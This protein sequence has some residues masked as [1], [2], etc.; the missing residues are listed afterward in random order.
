MVNTAWS[1]RIKP[2]GTLYL[3]RRLRFSDEY[4]AQYQTAFSLDP[5]VETI[6]EI[7]CGPGAFA[8][9]LARWYP[10]AHVTGI[11]LDTA[12]I[13]FAARQAPNIRFLQADAANLPFEEGSFD[14]TV[15]NT[16][17]EHLPP[18]KFFGQQ[19]Q[20]LKP[21]G[22]CLVLSARRGVSLSAPC[23]AERSPLE[24]EIWKR[25]ERFFQSNDRG[26][27]VGQYWMNER[28]LPVAMAQ[29]GF[30]HISTSYLAVNLTPDNPDHS[31]EQALAMIN[32]NRQNDLDAIASLTCVAPGLAAS[33]E[34]EEVKAQINQRYDR[35]L[36]L[37]RAGTPQWDT[38][39]SLTM[40]IRGVK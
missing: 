35:R 20:V 34:L 10:N 6:L 33:W 21:G 1:D 25:A 18:D 40:I 14:V 11:D 16:V 7:G 24:Q 5:G 15:S 3:S 23:V 19:Y 17:Q 4:Q 32:A 28:E 39:V 13:Q 27:S 8:Q 22:L 29:A 2:I 38:D 30:R 37:Y 9:S 36:Q 31:S 12:F 26:L